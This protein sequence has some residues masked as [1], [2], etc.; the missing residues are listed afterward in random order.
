MSVLRRIRHAWYTSFAKTRKANRALRGR[1]EDQMVALWN[2]N[3]LIAD[4]DQE[5]TELRGENRT[6]QQ[7]ISAMREEMEMLRKAVAQQGVAHVEAQAL[8]EAVAAE[9]DYWQG[10]AAN[11]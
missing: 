3:Q 1:V 6:L 11:P 10:K 2:R 9:R 4:Q 5:I 8:L 7:D